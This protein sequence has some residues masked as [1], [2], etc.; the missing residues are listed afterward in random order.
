MP[1]LLLLTQRIPYPP[2]KGEKI[3]ALHILKHLGKHYD[4][5]LGS[6][7]DDPADEEHVTTVKA[8]CATSYFA[9]LDRRRAKLTCLSGLLTGEPLSVTFYR[10]RKLQRWVQRTIEMVKP[11]VVFVFSSNMAPYVLGRLSGECVSLCDLVDVDSEKW[12]AYSEKGTGAMRLVHRREWRKMAKLEARIAQQFD[13]S[14]LVTAEEAALFRTRLPTFS[15]KI[16]TVPNG[17]DFAYFDPNIPLQTPYSLDRLNFV[18]AG[19]MDYPPN[20]DAVCWFA[21]SI[22]PIIRRSSPDAHFHIVGLNP[23]QEVRALVSYP[24]ISVTGRVPDVRPYVA[25]ATASVAPMRIA[26]GIQNKVLEAMAM[27]RPVVVTSG[28]LEGIEAVPGRE[29]LVANNAEDFAACCIQTGTSDVHAIGLAARARIERDFSWEGKL[30]G[31]DTLLQAT[32]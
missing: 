7:I 10:D 1:E 9:R 28:A 3:R 12:R 17:V 29:L 2:I 20:V 24:G 4:V 27:G 15:G 11:D 18:F 16:H 26:R 13:W 8:L 25:H 19:A 14:T 30:R 6:L 31:F 21:T 32:T 23:T 5:H 22:L